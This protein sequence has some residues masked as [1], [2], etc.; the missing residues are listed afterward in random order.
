M[1]SIPVAMATGRGAE[2]VRVGS[3]TTWRKLAFSSPQA[4]LRCDSSWAMSANDCAS[5]PVP[6]VVG[7]TDGRQHRSSGLVDP[8]VVLHLAAVG[9]Q[10][11]DSL[12]AVHGAAAAETDDQVDLVLTGE[13]GAGLHVA[14]RR[15]LFDPVEDEHFAG[16]LA[17]QLS[18]ALWIPCCPHTVIG[19]DEGAPAAQLMNQI[20]DLRQGIRPAVYPDAADRRRPRRGSLFGKATRSGLALQ[21]Q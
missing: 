10:E 8:P 12:G 20:T 21:C 17:D 4:I 16:F 3:R 13:T 15:V 5:L 2:A 19:N 18:G 6:A 9:E 1:A 14:S 7:N 11:V